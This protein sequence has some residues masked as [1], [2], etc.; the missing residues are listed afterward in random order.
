MVSRRDIIEY[1]GEKRT[2]LE[3]CA[4]KGIPERTLCARL[5]RGWSVEEAL[6]KKR[7]ARPKRTQENGE[8]VDANCVDCRFSVLLH[9]NV[10]N[11]AGLF[12]ACDYIGITGKRRPCPY[13]KGCTVKE[14]MHHAKAKVRPK[15]ALKGRDFVED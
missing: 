3:W 7:R 12:Y 9:V 2:I 8:R 1:N 5:R 14:K 15:M 6:N 13:G 4:I 10:D 11:S